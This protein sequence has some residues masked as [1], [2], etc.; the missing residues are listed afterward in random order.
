MSIQTVGTGLNTYAAPKT[1]KVNFGETQP[2]PKTDA[3]SEN[4]EK[5]DGWGY[6]IASVPLPGLGQFLQGR[7]ADGLKQLGA[8]LGL[9]ILGKLSAAAGLAAKNKYT[10]IAGIAAGVVSGLA[11]T[12]AWIYSIVDAFKGGKKD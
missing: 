9:T 4:K 11:G 1:K 5:K 10:K 8:V 3:V 7:T 2:A 12:G 6:A